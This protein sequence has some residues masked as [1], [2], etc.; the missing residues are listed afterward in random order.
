MQELWLLV[1]IEFAFLSKN[2][3]VVCPAEQ[4]TLA[5]SIALD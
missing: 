5:G 2:Q 1:E 3:I 4:I